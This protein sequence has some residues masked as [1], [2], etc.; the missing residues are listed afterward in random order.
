MF[1]LSGI[2]MHIPGPVYRHSS[3]MRK[4]NHDC[5]DFNR[6]LCLTKQQFDDLC[7]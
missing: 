3:Y 6:E 7:R 1:R 5:L 2:Y 4:N